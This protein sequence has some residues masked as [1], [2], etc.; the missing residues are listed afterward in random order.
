[1]P[2]RSAMRSMAGAWTDDVRHNEVTGQETDRPAP[3]S[4]RIPI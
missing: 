2:T 1:M 3:K 4:S